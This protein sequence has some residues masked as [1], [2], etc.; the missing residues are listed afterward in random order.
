[1]KSVR[2]A[3]FPRKRLSLFAALAGKNFRIRQPD[4]SWKTKVENYLLSIGVTTE[5]IAS[6]REILIEKDVITNRRQEP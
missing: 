6:I 5:E 3:T 2:F 1:M 4:D